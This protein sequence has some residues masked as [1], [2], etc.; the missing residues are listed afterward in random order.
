MECE[1]LKGC[2]FFNDFMPIDRGLGQIQKKKYCEGDK[3][4]VPGVK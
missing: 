2:L 3:T 1:Y 4:R